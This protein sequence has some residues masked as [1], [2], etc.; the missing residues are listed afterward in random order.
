MVMDVATVAQGE[1]IVELVKGN[2]L[3]SEGVRASRPA[4]EGLPGVNVCRISRDH[5]WPREESKTQRL[6]W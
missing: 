4:K 5:R 2:I 3:Y 1:V 6:D